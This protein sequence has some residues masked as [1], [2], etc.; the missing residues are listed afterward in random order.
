[1]EARD[2]DVAGIAGPAGPLYSRVLL[3]ASLRCSVLFVSE[4]LTDQVT[5]VRCNQEVFGEFSQSWL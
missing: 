3:L 5:R 2:F 4:Q 1:M